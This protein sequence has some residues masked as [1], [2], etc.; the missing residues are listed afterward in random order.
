MCVY[1]VLKVIFS[2]FELFRIS[3]ER[4]LLMQTRR[5]SLEIKKRKREENEKY[6]PD[7][8]HHR[9]K[10]K[11]AQ[12]Y[13]CKQSEKLREMEISIKDMTARIQDLEDEV[14]RCHAHS[15]RTNFSTNSFNFP[16]S[17]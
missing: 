4:I 2:N 15:V 11:Y 17:N 5:Q 10:I 6:M 16:L 1:V 7:E 13:R 3:T 9:K 12:E 14:Q 8:D